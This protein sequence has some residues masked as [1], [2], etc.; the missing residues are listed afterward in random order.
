MSLSD[1]KE[2][3]MFLLVSYGYQFPYNYALLQLAVA[4]MLFK[5]TGTHPEEVIKMDGLER[6]QRR[7]VM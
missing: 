3:V 4:L 6:Q 1:T 7:F 2:L 5:F